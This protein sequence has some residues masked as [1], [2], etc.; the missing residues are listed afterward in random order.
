MRKL[1]AKPLNLLLIFVPIAIIAELGHWSPVIIFLTAALAVVPL[2]GLLGDA[3]EELAGRTGPRIG[4]LLNATLGNAAELIIT[5]L[6]LREGLYD[7]VRASITGSIIGNL[8]LVAGA[9][10]IVGGLKHGTQQFS[11]K[12]AGLNATL[13]ILAAMVLVVPS[14]FSIA[15]EPARA[16]IDNISIITAGVIIVLYVLSLVF[17]FTSKHS[18]PVTRHAAHVPH[19]SMRVAIIMLVVSTLFIAGMSEV[20]VSAVEPMV[21][22]IGISELFVGVI[23]VPIIGNVAEHVVAIE[24][25]AKNKMDLSM[26]IAVGSSLQVALFVAPLLVFISLIFG[27]TLDLEFTSF[28]LIALLASCFIAAHVSVDGETNWL[29]G[30]MLVGLYIIIA[31]A[32]FFV[33]FVPAVH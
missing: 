10:L 23:L 28:E 26:G 30:V 6:A 31:V 22:Q 8:L 9:S 27:R 2:S 17:G 25:A 21:K 12:D 19:M 20:L 15:I 1:F 4:A 24:V 33:P 5:V 13:L 3:T 32:F 7:L 18:E 14:L 16:N 11:R 29:E